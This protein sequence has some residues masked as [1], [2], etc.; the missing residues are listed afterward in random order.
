MNWKCFAS[1]AFFCLIVS[2]LFAQPELNIIQ[3]GIQGGNFVWEVG[4]TPD[5]VLAEG[6]TPIAVELGFRLTG[7]P[8]LSATNINPL[9]FDTVNPGLPIFGWETL[10]DVDP[11]PGVNLRPVGLQVN[12]PTD[13]IFV[14]YG[15]V[16]FTTPGAK[17]FLQIVAQGP[18]NGGPSLS[19][20][21]EWLGV[22]AIGHGRIA[23]LTSR[24]T[25]ENF[26][27]FAG[28]DTQVVPEPASAVLLAFASAIMA[29]RI[30]SRRS[31][32]ALPG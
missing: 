2:P 3:G 24:T 17:P 26:D 5:L 11:G 13:E 31:R 9:E 21:I 1:A 23:Q 30:A 18:A 27:T 19:S 22:Y 4:V 14:A 15:T 16:D 7:A 25:S 32:R 10:T 20:T 29:V 6:S 12:P 28:S 8:L